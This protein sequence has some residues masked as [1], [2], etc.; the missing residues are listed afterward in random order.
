MAE[1]TSSTAVPGWLSRADD[2]SRTPSGMFADRG[3]GP[4]LLA[5]ADVI[6]RA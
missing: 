4:G 1:L 6:V 2:A 3:A 5:A